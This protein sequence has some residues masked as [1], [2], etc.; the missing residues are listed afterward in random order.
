MTLRASELSRMQTTVGV[1][2]DQSCSITRPSGAQTSSNRPSGATTSVATGV[3]CRL[4][5]LSQRK[6]EALIAEGVSGNVEWQVTLPA[7]V[8][9]VKSQDTITISSNLYRVLAVDPQRQISTHVVA[10]C[11]RI[12]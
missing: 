2:L 12:V 4:D 1:W 3:A 6:R 5:P 10:H 7:S 8:A 9:E 11:V